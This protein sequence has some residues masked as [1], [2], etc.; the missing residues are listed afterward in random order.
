MVKKIER[1]EDEVVCE[2]FLVS[3]RQ[4]ERERSRKSFSVRNYG[5]NTWGNLFNSRQKL[6]LITFVD[7]VREAYRKME[8]RSMRELLL[9][10]WVWG[11]TK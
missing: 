11:L 7:K 3:L 9:L 8:T 1:I 6:A 10:T 5:L 4:K 2:R